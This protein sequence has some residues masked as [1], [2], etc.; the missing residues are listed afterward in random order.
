[1]SSD[2]GIAG[3]RKGHFRSHDRRSIL[4]TLFYYVIGPGIL[5]SR[6]K[7]SD[8]ARIRFMVGKDIG[9]DAR[10]EVNGEVTCEQERVL[11]SAN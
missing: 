2:G 8:E 6:I 5:T 9:A 11:R 7:V 1:M 4:S 10:R 3:C